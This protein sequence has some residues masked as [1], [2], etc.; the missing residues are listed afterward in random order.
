MSDFSFTR[1]LYDDCSLAKKNQENTASFNWITDKSVVESKHSCYQGTSP[2]M[3]NPFKSIPMNAVD[4]ESNLRGQ[5]LKASRCPI[6]KFNPNN[7]PYSTYGNVLHDCKDNKLVPEYTRLNKACNIFSGININ[8]FNPL[9]EDLTDLNK[10]HSNNYIGI[11]TR[12]IIK[13]SFKK[14]Q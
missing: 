2:F 11:N 9:C 7:D 10:I 12:L 14:K 1:N 4:I 6:H 8:R 13:D 3:H 5:H